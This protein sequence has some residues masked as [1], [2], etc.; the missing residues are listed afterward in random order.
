MCQVE[1]DYQPKLQRP[2]EHSVSRKCVKCKEE[3]AAVLIRAGDPYCRSCFRDYFTHKFRAMLG[4]TRLIFPGEKVLLAISGGPSSSAMLSQVQQGLSQSAQKKLRFLPAIVHID[5]GGALGLSLVE[6]Q[7]LVSELQVIFRASGF[8]FYT[9][10]LEQVL[11]LPSSVVNVAPPSF[12]QAPDSYKAA[13]DVDLQGA[14]RDPQQGGGVPEPRLDESQTRSLQQ[15]L[16]S[17][18]TLTARAELLSTLRQHLLVHTARTRGYSKLLLG[19]SCSRLAVRLLTC[20]SLGRGAH[21]AQ[22]TGFSDCRFGDVTLVRPM[23]EFSAKEIAVYNHMFGVPTVIIPTLDT[24]MPEK[25]SI[26]RLSQSFVSRLQQDFPS[27]VSTIY[28]SGSG[29]VQSCRTSCSFL[30]TKL[31][32]MQDQREAADSRR[33]LLRPGRPVSAVRLQRG[34]G[35]REGLSAPGPADLRTALLS[36][37]CRDG[38]GGTDPPCW[39]VLFRYRWRVW[40]TS[41]WRW[42]L[43]LTFQSSREEGAAEAAVLQLPADPQRHVFSGS[44]SSVHRSRG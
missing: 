3:L 17:A 20:V 5:E 32:L 44:S 42:L 1:E 22:D 8:N 25:A 37:T 23:R 30:T 28:R 19:E 21:L 43:L 13:V 36:G 34:H 10:P 41:R 31:C 2:E 9:I 29:S 38:A 7:R 14:G 4:K 11:D 35:C 40:E 33:G 18:A 27:T 24:K 15:L 6:R 16:G 12:D 39:T 26:Q